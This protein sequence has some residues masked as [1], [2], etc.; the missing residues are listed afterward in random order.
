MD[1]APYPDHG[2]INDPLWQRLWGTYSDVI[3][4]LRAAGLDTDMEMCGGEFHIQV[5]LG[6]GTYLTVAGQDALPVD[7]NAS[8]ENGPE[9]NGWSVMRLHREDGNYFVR[10]YDS[11]DDGSEHANGTTVPPM[12]A[13]IA[14]HLTACDHPG[15]HASGQALAIYLAEPFASG[16]R[17]DIAQHLGHANVHTTAARYA[18]P[19]QLYRLHRFEFSA[20][21]VGPLG[22]IE[23]GPY[24]SFCEAVKQYGW[25]TH[26]LQTT[27]WLL[28]HQQGGTQAPLTV[29]ARDGRVHIAYVRASS[30]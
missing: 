8:T 29:W 10:I 24:D 11:T 19:A 3:T 2:R 30:S 16:R 5:E 23:E 25:H 12:L 4:P 17:E 28:L 18:A 20:R 22:G 9:L 7:R 6:D 13:A 14:H 1:P 26:E 15:I 27:G 21:H